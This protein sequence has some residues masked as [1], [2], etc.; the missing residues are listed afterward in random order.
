M[1]IKLFISEL[2]CKTS[3]KGELAFL[4]LPTKGNLLINMARNKLHFYKLRSLKNISK[5]GKMLIVL[6]DSTKPLFER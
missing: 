1:A 2:F 5:T 3:F 6:N 4:F